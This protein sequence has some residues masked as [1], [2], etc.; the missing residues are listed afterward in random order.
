[1]NECKT[2]NEEMKSTNGNKCV[3]G[4][5][6]RRDERIVFGCAS[7]N[8]KS[9]VSLLSIKRMLSVELRLELRLELR[10]CAHCTL[11]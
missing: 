2:E 10:M 6:E 7:G 4:T 9:P 8:R 11:Q 3:L 5:V 1:M